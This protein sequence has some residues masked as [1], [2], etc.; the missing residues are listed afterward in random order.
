MPKCFYQ[1]GLN[2]WTFSEKLLT[3]GLLKMEEQNAT[4][5]NAIASL[6]S[7]VASMQS[8]LAFLLE[9]IKEL[10]QENGDRRNS[11]DTFATTTRDRLSKIESNVGLGRWVATILVGAI[12]ALSASKIYQVLQADANQ[13][14]QILKK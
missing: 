4:I 11:I 13:V 8:N 5:L 6:Q 10:K 14:E 1:I 12:L 2:Y 3:I 9:A 7:Q